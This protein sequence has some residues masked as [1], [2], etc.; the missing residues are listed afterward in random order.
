MTLQVPFLDFWPLLS[1][2][3]YSSEKVDAAETAL[4]LDAV[5]SSLEDSAADTVVALVEE[6]PVE[7]VS[8]D[9]EAEVLAEVAPVEVGN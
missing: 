6:A 8:V 7:V 2:S 4:L 9:S 5:D 1:L 3:F